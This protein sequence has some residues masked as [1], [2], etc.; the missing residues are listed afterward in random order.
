MAPQPVSPK[1]AMTD[2]F[3]AD[4][5]CLL[6]ISCSFCGDESRT[7]EVAVGHGNSSTSS[8]RFYALCQMF[9]STKQCN[10]IYL[11]P[12]HGSVG[13]DAPQRRESLK[14]CRRLYHHVTVSGAASTRIYLIS[15]RAHQRSRPGEA[16]FMRFRS[17]IRGGKTERTAATNWSGDA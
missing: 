9:K 15:L 12:D 5:M 10:R 7:D 4:Q 16:C 11:E 3:R 2:C 6:V 14:R 13:Q 1:F 17:C 8:Q